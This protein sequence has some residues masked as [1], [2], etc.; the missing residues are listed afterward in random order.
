MYDYQNKIWIQ[1]A[2]RAR[3]ISCHLWSSR[4]SFLMN[5]KCFRKSMIN[6]R[7]W[8]KVTVSKN[9][10][11]K[12]YSRVFVK[13][14]DIWRFPVGIWSGYELWEAINFL[15]GYPT[16]YFSN[17]MYLRMKQWNI[18][19]LPNIYPCPHEFNP[20]TI[21]F[22]ILKEYK[23]GKHGRGIGK[24]MTSQGVFGDC[25]TTLSKKGW[26]NLGDFQ[27]Q[28]LG[29][30]SLCDNGLSVS[31]WVNLSSNVSRQFLL[32][33]GGLKSRR[34]GFLVRIF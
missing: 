17:M 7:C 28:C 24:L 26:I 12:S 34:N 10:V 14:S 32:G 3:T 11:E 29:K 8:S 33:T 31:F 4:L 23:S 18:G 22:D 27:D 16:I 6:L 13:F 20:T 21:Y 2:N 9:E 5:W 19:Y 25:V 15:E 30:P 1:I